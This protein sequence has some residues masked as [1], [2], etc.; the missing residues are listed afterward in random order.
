MATW[1]YSY[2]DVELHRESRVECE[3][4]PVEGNY[5]SWHDQRQYANW[6]RRN[7]VIYLGDRCAGTGTGSD[8]K[9]K[10]TSIS[11]PLYNDTSN[12]YFTLTATDG[13]SAPLYFTGNL[14]LESDLDTRPW[15]G[16]T[17]TPDKGGLVPA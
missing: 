6:Q 13:D 3:D 5:G 14:A 17:G 8:Y 7:R 16:Y 4:Y 1:N 10:I 15:Y 2:R 11:N 9:V 12:N